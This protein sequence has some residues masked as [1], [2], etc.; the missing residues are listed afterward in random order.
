MTNKKF[1]FSDYH[2]P[3]N[4]DFDNKIKNTWL[5][6]P[7]YFLLIFL[8]VL[9]I[10]GGLI[11]YQA[12][13][14]V[15]SIITTN[16]SPKT[17]LDAQVSGVSQISENNDYNRD[18]VNILLLGTGGFGHPGGGLTDVIQVLSINLKNDK[19]LIFSIPRD[20]YVDINGF[21]YHK[22]NTA[23]NLGESLGHGKG[24]I[25]VKKEVE[26]VLGLPIHYYL[27]IDF[28]GFEEIVDI[29][30][31]VEVCV[32]KS[33]NDSQHGTYIPT[34]CQQMNGS[35]ALAYARSRYTTSDFDRSQRQQKLI[36]AI[37]N[38]ILKLN[39]LLNPIKINQAFSVLTGNL[40]T[41][42]KFSELRDMGQIFSKISKDNITSYVLDNR[43]NDLLYS[44]MQNGAYV[45]LPVGGDFQKIKKFVKTKMP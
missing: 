13:K 29:L 35:Q 8:L 22:I 1:K 31:G 10:G 30:G 4:F 12:N 32:D 19:A 21:G 16:N 34:G 33:I 7:Y 43:K 39:F 40:N 15:N 27:K 11:F 45:L 23:Y 36:F 6:K 2:N 9:S 3:N 44:K 42:I 14:N 38:K 5:R 25:L 18:Y 37:K 26:Q 17:N 28:D 20:L 41:D 24:G